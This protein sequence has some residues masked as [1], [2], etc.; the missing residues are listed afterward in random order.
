LGVTFAMAVQLKFWG[1]RGSIA[2]PGPGTIRYGGNT[3]C[4]EVR[5][6]DYTLIL[7][8]GTG[9]RPFGDALLKDGATLDADLFLTHCHLDHVSGLPFFAPLFVKNHHLRIWAG[10]LPADV[11][12]KQALR[13]MMSPPLFPID[14]E[15]FQARME[16]RDF[17]PGDTLQP[18][19][20]VTLHTGML[21]HPG[22]AIG[23]RLESEGKVLAYLTDTELPQ[24]AGNGELALAR[25]ADLLIFDTTYTD[26]EIASRRGWGHST[27][28]DGVRLAKAAGAK[29]LCMFH[30]DPSHDDAFM[31]KLGAEAA[32]AHPGTIVAREGLVID[33]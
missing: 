8:G 29:K 24:P 22:G 9:L 15:S 7:D 18:R 20:G 17:H 2:C 16:Y 30:H 28:K 3:P 33:L 6:G 21:N 4:V 12:I 10:N 13:T 1:V 25:N 23:Y 27:W 31:D 32:A 5:C 26:A 14:V 19:P 11:S